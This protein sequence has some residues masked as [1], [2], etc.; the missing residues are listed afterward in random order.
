MERHRGG[1]EASPIAAIA[2][3]AFIFV[4]IADAIMSD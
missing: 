1:E 4:I 3:I 2:M